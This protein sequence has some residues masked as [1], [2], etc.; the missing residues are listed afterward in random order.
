MK[1]ILSISVLGAVFAVL[2]YFRADLLKVY[3]AL[4]EISN[5]IPNIVNDIKKEISAPAPLRS[6]STAPAVVLTKAGVIE[7]TNIERQNN[8]GLPVL[9]ENTKLNAAAQVK[10]KDMFAKQYFEHVSPLGIGPGDLV[11]AQGYDYIL[12]GENL[13]LGNFAGDKDLVTAWMNSPGH[14]ANILNNRYREIGVAV[15][16]GIYEGHET[17]LAVQEFGLSLSA[18]PSPDKML[19]TDIY[20]GEA[21]LN[22]LKAE[23]ENLKAELEANEPK[24]RKEFGE[25]NQKVDE[26]NSLVRQINSLIDEIKTMVIKYNAEVQAFNLCA[27]N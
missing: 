17:W 2:F 3:K 13:A 1:K 12:A 21:G 4:P 24:T 22:I 23:A 26:Y 18:C 7:R 19:Q 14:R 6:S 15:G 5:N 10:L 20:G 16:K 11:E 27:G 8:G 25:Y 9:K